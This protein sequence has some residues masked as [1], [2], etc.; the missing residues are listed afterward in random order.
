MAYFKWSYNLKFEKLLLRSILN[1]FIFTLVLPIVALAAERENSTSNS[2]AGLGSPTLNL[3]AFPLPSSSS[4]GGGGAG[5]ASGNSMASIGQSSFPGMTCPLTENRPYQDLVRAI[6]NLAR[7]V[8][9]TPECKN[10]SDLLAMQKEL[11]EILKSGQNLVGVWNS[12]N[13]SPSLGAQEIGNF[14][15]DITTVIAGINNITNTFQNNSFL[16]GQCGGKLMTGSGVLMAVS[17]LVTSIAP[18]ALIGA[19]MN[20]SL[21]IALPYILGITGVGSVAK[22]I[23]GMHD[24]NTLDMNR[25]E[26]RQAVLDNVCEFSRISQ[27]VRF[28]KLAQSGQINIINDEL[29]KM[30]VTYHSKLKEEYSH[31]TF[32]IKK[33]NDEYGSKMKSLKNALF[34]IKNSHQIFATDMKNVSNELFCSV[35]QS[36]IEQSKQSTYPLAVGH[37]FT[38]I[39]SLQVEGTPYQKSLLKVYSSLV[40]DFSISSKASSVDCSSKSRAF[41]EVISKIIEHSFLTLDLLDQSLQ[42]QC[43]A[44]PDYRSLSAKNKNVVHEVEFLTKVKDLLTQLNSDNALLDKM[45]LD[46]TIYLL[47]QSLF[48]TPNGIIFIRGASPAMSWLEFVWENHLRSLNNFKND[49]Q[50][51]ANELFKNT[52]AYHLDYI[53]KNKKGEVIKDIFGNPVKYNS[54]PLRFNDFDIQKAYKNDYLAAQNLSLIRPQEIP[55]G[56]LQHTRACRRLE[57]LWISWSAAIDHLGATQFFCEY[58]SEFFSPATEKSILQ[59][60]QGQ[61]DIYGQV[62]KLSD[63]EQTLLSLSQNGLKEKANYVSV[64]MKQMN[65]PMP[66]MDVLK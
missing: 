2:D 18:F 66:T 7:V 63:I 41:L 42:K 12:A 53:M 36:L 56:T 27:R 17:D 55:E 50:Q 51:L 54:N 9:I 32:E 6:Q 19:S 37:L 3:P 30:E 35:T 1:I 58:I 5:R 20:P 10:D 40:K 34:E 33:I 29:I 21:K 52:P 46:S 11:E 48:G 13:Q 47:N 38:S 25:F 16:E 49:Y 64:K 28:L 4:V 61:Q 24:K 22:I 14:Q 31:R 15:S 59:R 57:N 45:E 65:C 44:D 62:I 60:C 23:K 26:H 39:L 43:S 8:V